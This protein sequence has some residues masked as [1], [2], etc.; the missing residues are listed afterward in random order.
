[1][2]VKCPMFSLYLHLLHFQERQS[3]LGL[4]LHKLQSDVAT[5]WNSSL[6]MV[7]RFIEQRSAIYATLCEMKSTEVFSNVECS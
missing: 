1:M 7:T 6:E 3:Q 5:R 4:P 2:D